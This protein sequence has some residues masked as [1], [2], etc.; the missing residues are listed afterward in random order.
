MF[1]IRGTAD[2]IFIYRSVNTDTKHTPLLPG[3]YKQEDTQGSARSSFSS[4]WKQTANF[5]TELATSTQSDALLHIIQSKRRIWR[6]CYHLVEEVRLMLSPGC[7]RYKQLVYKSNLR[8]YFFVLSL[9][10]VQCP[11]R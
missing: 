1:S 2:T 5:S 10:D 11:Y 4:F 9:L 7:S 6:S 8:T 3:P